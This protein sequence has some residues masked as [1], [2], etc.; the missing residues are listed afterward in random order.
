MANADGSIQVLL[1]GEIYNWRELREQ[2]EE[3]GCQFTT[4]SDTEVIVKG[5]EIWKDEIV[6]KLTGMFA[7]AIWEKP[8][9]Q[10]LL[11]RDRLGEKPLY[12]SLAN[13]GLIFASNVDAI[14]R[15]VENRSINPVA[16][17][18]YLAHSFIPS[19]CTV[20]REI[21]V[22][23]P[24]HALR[25]R[26]DNTVEV[27][28]YWELPRSKPLRTTFQE[29]ANRIQEAIDESVRR[30]LDA[31]VPVGLFLS[32]GVDSSLIAAL[33]TRHQPRLPAFSLGFKEKTHSEIIYAD[34]VA[35]HLD[36][37]HYVIE[38]GVE[39]V[40]RCLPHLIKEYGQPFGDASAVPT[41]LVSQFAREQVKVCLS[42]DG[43]DE[44]FGGYWRVQSAVY[45]ERYSRFVPKSVRE[46]IVPPVA[47]RLGNTGRRWLAMNDLSLDPIGRS[48]TNSLSWFNML[49]DVAGPYL[50]SVL[51]VDLV[52]YRVGNSQD[53]PES[54]N[55]Q[56]LLFDDIEVQLP[57]CYLAKVDVASMAAS[58]EVRCPF[59]EKNIMEQAWLLPDRFKLHIGQRKWLLKKI[60]S[61][62]V[63]SEVVYRQK[64][65]F[66][67]PLQKWFQE[68]L[69]DYLGSLMADSV[70][71]SKGW[72]RSEVV[73][74]FL[75]EHRKGEDH[76]TRLWLALWLEMWFRYLD[77][78]PD[79]NN[80]VGFVTP[81]FFRTTQK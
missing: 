51:A 37:P 55:V 46:Y 81:S 28:R 73:K 11:V 38:V 52:S 34:K 24:A 21:S 35:R 13:E 40:L 25:I 12:Y 74:K 48:Y 1:N 18:C 31:D 30:C 16:V 61:R 8:T 44:A 20:W 15:V 43:G 54:S 72:L 14:A 39:D 68:D 6:P 22:L 70:A 26:L 42:G 3:L 49:H 4:Q 77:S 66:T 2:L 65:G 57:D 59:L 76:Q 41:F 5:Y 47:S 9:K 60:A 23:P 36:I 7:I 10:L 53:R 33:A 69:G 80:A 75:Y 62:F 58:L 79:T 29:A 45:A 17:A 32:G 78:T 50:K 67:M 19:K 71:D 63:P 56:K 64:M 27:R